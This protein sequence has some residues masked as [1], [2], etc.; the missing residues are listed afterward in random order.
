MINEMTMVSLDRI[1]LI[2]D[3]NAIVVLAAIPMRIITIRMLM[4]M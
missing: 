1:E 4:R 2:W 3:T